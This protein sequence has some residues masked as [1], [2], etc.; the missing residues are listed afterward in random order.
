FYEPGSL[1]PSPASAGDHDLSDSLLE[2]TTKSGVITQQRQFTAGD[3]WGHAFPD[4]F[5]F[6]VGTPPNLFSIPTGNGRGQ[7]DVVGVGDKE[8]TYY[9]LDRSSL[10][11]IWIRKV[12]Q[13]SLIG[14]FQ[15]MAAVGDGVAYAASQQSYVVLA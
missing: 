15:R 3:I 6:D 12:S 7:R 4:G 10:H 14:G 9:A 8:G 13:G 11:P 1:H 5:D 2:L